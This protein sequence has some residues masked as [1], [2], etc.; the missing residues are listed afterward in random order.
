MATVWPMY[1]I[2]IMPG[3]LVIG[4]ALCRISVVHRDLVLVHVT[5]VHVME[6]TV[7]K[8]VN[9]SIVDD[10]D[11]ATIGAMLVVV[12]LMVRCVASGHS[13]TPEHRLD[14]GH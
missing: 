14:I 2:G 8:I 9:V 1:V 11:M 5:F 3:T 10:G 12:V 4:R 6:M 7:V 13:I